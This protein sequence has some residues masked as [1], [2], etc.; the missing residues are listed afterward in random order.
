MRK[1]LFMSLVSAGLFYTSCKKEKEE[2]DEGKLPAIAFKT[3]GNYITKDTTIAGGT[4]I[5]IGIDAHKTEDRD[6]LKKFD[7]S[8]AVNGGTSSSIYNKD[9]T[10]AEEDN[11]SYDYSAT[12]D[13][14]SGQENKYT[15]S[16]TNRDGLTN[17][18]SLTITV[19]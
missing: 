18:V 12:L 10:G 6:V 7:I 17:K 15:F 5:L 11:Y 9:L 13:T 14:T 16:V 3:G 8:K 19:Q 2:H 4:N 1:L